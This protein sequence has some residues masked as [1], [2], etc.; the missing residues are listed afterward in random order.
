MSHPCQGSV[1]SETGNILILGDQKWTKIGDV[2]GQPDQSSSNGFSAP[3]GGRVT[4]EG[5]EYDYVFDIDADNGQMLKLPYNLSV[6][7]WHAAQDFI[8]KNELPQGY[9][10][11]IAQFII[12]NSDQSK[13]TASS[14][15]SVDPF[16]GSGAYSSSSGSSNVRVAYGGDPFTGGGAYTTNGGGGGV[17]MEVDE[18]NNN[19]FPPTDLVSFPQQPKIEAMMKKLKEF[20]E[21]VAEEDKLGDADLERLPNLCGQGMNCREVPHKFA[22]CSFSPPTVVV[23]TLSLSMAV[24]LYSAMFLQTNNLQWTIFRI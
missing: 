20:N 1:E 9:L 23:L 14:G 18:A 8:H 15:G 22:G 19:H 3:G 12:K 2:V 6:D 21:Q 13:S 4:F 11:T 5:K 17:A 10:E 24:P 7:P 16:T